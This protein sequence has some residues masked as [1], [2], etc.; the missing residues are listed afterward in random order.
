MYICLISVLQQCILHGNG[1]HMVQNTGMYWPSTQ[2][3]PGLQTPLQSWF[4]I[5][6]WKDKVW[7]N[8]IK[9]LDT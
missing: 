1:D 5:I 4:M 6:V 9:T 3:Q 7:F 8:E 2:T